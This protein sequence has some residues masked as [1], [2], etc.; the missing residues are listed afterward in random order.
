[1]RGDVQKFFESIRFHK[2]NVFDLFLFFNL[3]SSQTEID[4]EGFFLK[5]LIPASG[6]INVMSL[7]D[8]AKPFFG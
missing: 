4:D 5:G 3:R 6:E 1:L 7:F 2:I 8:C